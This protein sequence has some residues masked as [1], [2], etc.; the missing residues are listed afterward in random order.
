MWLFALI[1][2]HQKLIMILS[3]L[4]MLHQINQTRGYFYHLAKCFNSSHERRFL[5][6]P[7]TMM[8][9]ELRS[10]NNSI[11]MNCPPILFPIRSIKVSQ[12]LW[13]RVTHGWKLNI[14]LV[15]LRA[16][17]CLWNLVIFVSNYFWYMKGFIKLV[18]L[19][20]LITGEKT[21]DNIRSQKALY[22]NENI[23]F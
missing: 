16:V 9:Q 4:L 23:L 3:C 18:N 13:I 22:I 7:R 2:L 12:K 11:L 8:A 14:E 1:Y 17:K 19:I 10:E 20:M 21:C 6:K 15:R 5:N